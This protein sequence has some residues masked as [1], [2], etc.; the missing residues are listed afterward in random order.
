[1]KIRNDFITNSSSTSF[2]F[3]KPNSVIETV[4]T[5]FN[6]TRMI[7]NEILFIYNSILMSLKSGELKKFVDSEADLDTINYYDILAYKLIKYHS[8][9]NFYRK[10][11]SESF[12]VSSSDSDA[13]YE[14]IYLFND[15]QTLQ[16][17]QDILN[18]NSYIQY[19]NEKKEFLIYIYDIQELDKESC[20]RYLCDL[21]RRYYNESNKLDPFSIQENIDNIPNMKSF[22]L[23]HFGNIFLQY[24]ECCL[25][26]VF[27]TT[28]D[29]YSSI[30]YNLSGNV[31]V[32]WI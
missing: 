32:H 6:F 5:I 26:D 9:K 10:L 2:I 31:M 1:M 8:F 13:I 25:M 29:Y 14:F 16:I 20:Y 19:M 22:V 27:E 4:D 24:E 7:S 12:L 21:V 30:S 18:Y 15:K 17:Y 23:S 28:L 11:L 3:G